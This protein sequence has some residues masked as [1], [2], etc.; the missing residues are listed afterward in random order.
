M[1]SDKFVNIKASS[2][3]W[4]DNRLCVLRGPG[5]RAGDEGGQETLQGYRQAEALQERNN[6]C[7]S[8]GAARKR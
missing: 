8:E 3:P 2:V 5:D 1:K 4:G 6:G 7:N